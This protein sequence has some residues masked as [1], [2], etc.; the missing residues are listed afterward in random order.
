[1][2]I[3]HIPAAQ[4]YR[5]RT[6]AGMRC[7]T[8]CCSWRSRPPFFPRS[9]LLSSA[10]LS[11]GPPLALLGLPRFLSG[12]SLRVC[13]PLTR[14]WLHSLCASHHGNLFSAIM[15]S[16]LQPPI[17][18]FLMEFKAQAPPKASAAAGVAVVQ[19]G[20]RSWSLS[21]SGLSR[22]SW[23]SFAAAELQ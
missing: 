9:W 14:R 15:S 7:H 5:C 20:K 4:D 10:Q 1:M 23:E 17:S 21:F 2:T 13:L 18:F 3:N 19:S 16:E 12:D 11:S 6:G 8:G 22:D